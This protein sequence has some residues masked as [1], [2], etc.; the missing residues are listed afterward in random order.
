[1]GLIG[2]VFDAVALTTGAAGIRRF[3]G[4]DIYRIVGPML[5]KYPKIDMGFKAYLNL[6]EFTLDKGTVLAKKTIHYL[7]EYDIKK[8]KRASG[9]AQNKIPEKIDNKTK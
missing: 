9:N 7:E 1:M 3:T 6:G 8:D 5:T 2:L 4:L